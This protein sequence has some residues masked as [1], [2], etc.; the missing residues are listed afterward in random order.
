MNIVSYR[1]KDFIVGTIYEIQSAKVDLNDHEII[2]GTGHS[3]FYESEK[4]VWNFLSN[5]SKVELCIY[6]KSDDKFVIMDAIRN[7]NFDIIV[8]ITYPEDNQHMHD[9][10]EEYYYIIKRRN[11][12]VNKVLI[13]GKYQDLI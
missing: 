9:T 10:P 12:M 2:K 8:K 7:A 6:P 5:G 3:I 1:D 4:S 11:L 13:N